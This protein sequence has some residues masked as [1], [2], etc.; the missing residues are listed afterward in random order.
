MFSP[1]YKLPL[2][3]ASN[4]FKNTGIVFYS[5][6]LSGTYPLALLSLL[7]FTFATLTYGANWDERSRACRG[8]AQDDH[9]TLAQ[10]S[11]A[12]H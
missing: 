10:P 11:R 9:F 7:I 5:I 1:D 4:H 2:S 3:L 8:R 6:V 12:L